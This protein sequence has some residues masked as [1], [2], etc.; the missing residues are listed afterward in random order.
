MF[1][2]IFGIGDEFIHQSSVESRRHSVYQ[3][4]I[5]LDKN[6]RSFSFAFAQGDKVLIKLQTG[7]KKQVRNVRLTTLSGNPVWSKDNASTFEEEISLSSEGV[8]TISVEKKGLFDQTIG[9]DIIRKPGAVADFN[10]AWTK[11]NRY[12]GENV[13]FK[14][15]TA[16]GYQSAVQNE[17]EMK[18]F[19]KYYYQN[20]SLYSY[21]DQVKGNLAVDGNHV[22]GFPMAIDPN[23]VPKDAKFK[24][25]TYSLSSVLGGQK[26]WAIAQLASQIGGTAASIFLTPAAGFAVH[27]AMAL[28]GPAPNKAPVMYYMSNRQ[29]DIKTVGEIKSNTGKAKDVANTVTGGVSKV[30]GLFS[31]DAAKTVKNATELDT[32][33]EADLDFTQKGNVTNLFV[34]S[35]IPPTEKYFIMTNSYLMQAK[36]INLNATALY[37]APSFFT[38]KAKEEVF[39]L[40]K[41]QMDKTETKYAKTTEYVSIKY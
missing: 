23:K 5:E 35:A 7:K 28:V 17:I 11:Q 34:N 1:I 26:H 15:D 13:T 16:V 18:V 37:Y 30:I 27:G 2:I 40:K 8:Y 36:N 6:G 3:G 32:K 41:A 31:D 20:I 12:I 19:N 10:P 33:T 21:G 39:N 29:S 24:C 4:N 25:Y 9:L 14:V 22:Q 38:V